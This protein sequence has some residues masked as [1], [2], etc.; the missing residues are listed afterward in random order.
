MQIQSVIKSDYTDPAEK[1][2]MKDFIL[3]EWIE[4]LQ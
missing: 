4:K 1:D 3:T 2:L